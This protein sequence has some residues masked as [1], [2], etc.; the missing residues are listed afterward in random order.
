MNYKTISS[1]HTQ[2]QL[3]TAAPISS[4]YLVF[5]FHFGQIYDYL[6]MYI[7]TYVYF[8]HMYI[9]IYIYIYLYSYIYIYIYIKYETIHIKP[10]SVRGKL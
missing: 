9:Y 5:M 10:S 1:T 6:L 3:Y 4:L 2:S 7:L 8:I